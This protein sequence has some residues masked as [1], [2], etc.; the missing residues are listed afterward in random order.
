M[1]KIDRVFEY[2]TRWKNLEVTPTTAPYFRANKSL[3]E[4]RLKGLQKLRDDI[5]FD[6][7]TAACYR[8]SLL[9]QV[10]DSI[11]ILGKPDKNEVQEII[12]YL[13]AYG[14]GVVTEVIGKGVLDSSKREQK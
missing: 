12:N 4:E 1:I 9:H 7:D 3:Y 5:V 14:A 2:W 10:F 6:V 13:T 11:I 8:D